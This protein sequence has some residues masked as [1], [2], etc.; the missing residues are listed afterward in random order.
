MAEGSYWRFCRPY[1]TTRE[2][3]KAVAGASNSVV[4][5]NQPG[6]RL[7]STF[8]RSPDLGRGTSRERFGHSEHEQLAG[9]NELQMEG[10]IG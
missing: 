8:D 7:Y 2:V 1:E 9:I 5:A 10:S 6:Q 4:G 3:I